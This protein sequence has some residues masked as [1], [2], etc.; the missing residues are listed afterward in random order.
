MDN[1]KNRAAPA[2]VFVIGILL[3][4]GLTAFAIVWTVRDTVQRT[5]L[6]VQAMSGDLSTRVSQVL[7]PTPTVLPN[8]ITVI[9]DVRSLAR[10]ETI[11][12][13]IEKVIKAEIG[14]GMFGELFGDKLIFVAHGIVIAGVDLGKFGA[15]DMELEDGI[16]YVNL[17]E[18]EVFLAT[19]DN[20]KSYVYDR[21]TGLLTKGDVNLESTARREAERE[22]ENAALEDGML[23]LA[24]QNAEV[25]LERLLNSLGYP[26]VIFIRPE[27]VITAT[28]SAP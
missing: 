20:E 19:L 6:P 18:P 3:I 2:W 13:R 28:P 25:Y 24:R 21:D 11:D 12:Y 14:Q 7:N 5:I 15:D 27:R 9:H 16:L 22:I 26:E 1:S 8:P 23:E 4:V 17:P 10:L